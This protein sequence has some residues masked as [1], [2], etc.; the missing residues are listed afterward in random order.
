MM[1]VLLQLQLVYQVVA[2]P[3]ASP[4]LLLKLPSL[5]LWSY[6]ICSS[7]QGFQFR[8]SRGSLYSIPPYHGCICDPRNYYSLVEPQEPQKTFFLLRIVAGPFF[9]LLIRKYLK[10]IRKWISSGEHMQ[11]HFFWGENLQVPGK[12]QTACII[13]VWRGVWRC[14][15]S[16]LAQ[17]TLHPLT[18]DRHY[19]PALGQRGERF[20]A[21]NLSAPISPLL[22][23]CANSATTLSLRFGITGLDCLLLL[24]LGCWWQKWE[25]MAMSGIGCWVAAA[26]G[27]P[28]RSCTISILR[29]IVRATKAAT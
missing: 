25:G 4:I 5:R 16:K 1:L 8:F 28:C 11:E 18:W 14:T 12:L 17:L 13:D 10:T 22:L 2:D 19:G 21:G 9:G 29:R 20:G 24:L 26:M 27:R 6:H 7:L 23:K 15:H 3:R